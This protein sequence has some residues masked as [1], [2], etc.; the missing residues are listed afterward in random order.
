MRGL[1]EEAVGILSGIGCGR[2][3]TGQPRLQLC[4]Q[5]CLRELD[6]AC[7]SGVPAAGD[8]LAYNEFGNIICSVIQHCSAAGFTIEGQKISIV[9]GQ[10]VT[11][12]YTDLSSEDRK[13]V[14]ADLK[15]PNQR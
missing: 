6:N 8:S 13:L 12:Y 1:L 2:L 7:D 3:Q 4:L 5:T 10:S 9:P 14:S 11:S 15:P